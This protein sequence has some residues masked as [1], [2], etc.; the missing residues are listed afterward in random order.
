MTT[1]SE[2]VIEL[3]QRVYNWFIKDDTYSVVV[4]VTH[5]Y[6]TVRHK[7][8]TYYVTCNEYC[9]SFKSGKWYLPNRRY[10]LYRVISKSG[11]VTK[12]GWYPLAVPA[13]MRRWKF[14]CVLAIRLHFSAIT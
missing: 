5:I 13:F 2:L 6:K 7:G 8:K 11:N 3:I 4:D 9:Y 14:A 1:L 12:S 10:Y